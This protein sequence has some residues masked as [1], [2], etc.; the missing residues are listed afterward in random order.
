M[1]IVFK[2]WYVAVWKSSLKGYFCKILSDWIVLESYSLPS[3][4]LEFKGG[5]NC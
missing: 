1:W 3:N 4:T 2:D 5:Y